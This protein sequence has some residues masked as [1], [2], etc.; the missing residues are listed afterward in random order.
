MANFKL[1]ELEQ[2]LDIGKTIA[3]K[4][5]DSALKGVIEVVRTLPNEIVNV[6]ND[7]EELTTKINSMQEDFNKSIESAKD[8]FFNDISIANNDLKSKIDGITDIKQEVLDEVNKLHEV[9]LETYNAKFDEVKQQLTDRFDD[10][11]KLCTET[12]LKTIGESENEIKA[13]AATIKNS[14][15]EI[16]ERTL[17][18]T[19]EVEYNIDNKIT[20]K[21]LS[22][23]TLKNIL[24]LFNP[25]KKK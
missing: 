13:I 8:D 5:N 18:I 7:I 14:N 20:E 11:V 17:A 16:I 23:F 1:G 4:N 3:D 15:A 9:A 24:A 21:I 2:I 6:K 22:Y 25:F 19:K 12:V 10:L